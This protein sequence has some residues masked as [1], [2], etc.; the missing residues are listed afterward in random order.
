MAFDWSVDESLENHTI[1]DAPSLSAAVSNLV[2]NAFSVAKNI[3]FSATL[4]PTGR[5][6]LEVID[7]G[8]GP[9]A[10]IAGEL[11]EPFVTSKPEGLGLGLPLVARAAERLGGQVEWNRSHDK[12]RFKFTANTAP[13]S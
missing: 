5:L 4:S 10:E 13:S 2:L 8:P 12:T 1:A 9:P 7:D 3:S 11:F 6:E